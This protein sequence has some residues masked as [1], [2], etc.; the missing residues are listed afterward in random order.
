MQW[1]L[2]CLTQY[3][4]FTGRARRKEYW[5]F[6][7]FS[8]L[9]YFLVAIVL[10]ALSATESAINIVIGLLAL[11]LMLPNLAVTI[12]RLHDTDRSGWWALLSFVP[13]LSLVILVFMFLD[14]TSGGNRFGPDPK[15]DSGDIIIS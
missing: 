9:I 4:D 1:F 5:M 14:G 11:S 8:L 13:I 10:V 12:R 2:K 7:L 6:V 3:A 15:V